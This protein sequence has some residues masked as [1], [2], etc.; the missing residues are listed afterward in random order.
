MRKRTKAAITQWDRCLQL[1]LCDGFYAKSTYKKNYII[2]LSLQV[3]L[4]FNFMMIIFFLL[5]AEKWKMLH[6]GGRKWTISLTW[7]P[8]SLSTSTWFSIL[9]FVISQ[10]ACYASY[11]WLLQAWLFSSSTTI[12]LPPPRPYLFINIA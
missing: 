11:K 7:L 8:S 5:V 12:H 9:I 10:F 3:H 4:R 6:G 2:P 1:F